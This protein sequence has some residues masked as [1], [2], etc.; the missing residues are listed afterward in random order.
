MIVFDNNLL[1]RDRAS[2]ASDVLRKEKTVKD[3]WLQIIKEF[4]ISVCITNIVF[5]TIVGGFLHLFTVI[6]VVTIF[7]T[8]IFITI[9]C[10]HHRHHHRRHHLHGQDQETYVEENPL[11]YED[12]DEETAK[13]RQRMQQFRLFCIIV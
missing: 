2:W 13:K 3:K 7:M 11:K 4:G 5:T 1:I 9:Y 6:I 12:V 10:H 8:I